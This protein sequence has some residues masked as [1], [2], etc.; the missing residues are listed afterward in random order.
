MGHQILKFV[1]FHTISTIK[2]EK[3]AAKFHYIKTVSG[4]VVAQSIAFRVVSRYWHGVAPFPWY[5]N[6]KGPTPIG[7]ACVA[8]S[9]VSLACIRLTGWLVIS[10]V[11]WTVKPTSK[12]NLTANPTVQPTVESTSVGSTVC[13]TVRSILKPC[14]CATTLENY[15]L[16]QERQPEIGGALSCQRTLKWTLNVYHTCM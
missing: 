11:G 14:I 7:I 3:S 12:Q 1:I 16:L 6:A 9:L 8:H 5:L 13:P 15:L 4:K 2:D 10:T